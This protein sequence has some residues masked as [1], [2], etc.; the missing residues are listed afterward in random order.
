MRAVLV[1]TTVVLFM[2]CK[3]FKMLDL[4]KYFVLRIVIALDILQ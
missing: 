1:K 3:N 4:Q 2:L